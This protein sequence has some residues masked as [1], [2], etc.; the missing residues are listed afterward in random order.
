MTFGRGGC[1]VAAGQFDPQDMIDKMIE[2]IGADKGNYR[3][4]WPPAT[5]ELI[6][7]VQQDAWTRQ[8]ISE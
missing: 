2:V 8:V 7:Q 4:V 1:V 3:N 5:E 6:K